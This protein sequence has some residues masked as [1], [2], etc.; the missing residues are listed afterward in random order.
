MHILSTSKKVLNPFP[1]ERVES[2]YTLVPHFTVTGRIALLSYWS[3]IS[4]SQVVL[5]Y[6][7][8]GPP[9]H[10]HRS[11]CTTVILVPHFTVTGRIAL[12]S[13]WSPISL[14]Q[15]ILH[16]CH[17]GPPFHC[18]RSYCTSYCHIGPPFHCHRSYCTTEA[19]E[20][21]VS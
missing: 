14:S 10:C 17:I 15:V 12:L 11:Y 7:H 9:F 2:G 5:H 18:H 8:I 6:C 4:L 20:Y 16:Y 1:R 21:G 3:P 13:Y 19:V